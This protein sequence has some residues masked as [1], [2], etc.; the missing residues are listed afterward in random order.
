MVNCNSTRIY[1]GGRG[2]QVPSIH[3]TCRACHCSRDCGD[4]CAFNAASVSPSSNR[5]ACKSALVRVS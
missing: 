3:N 4:H 2:R 1:S 5:F